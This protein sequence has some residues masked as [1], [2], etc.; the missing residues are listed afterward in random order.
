MSYLYADVGFQEK[1]WGK[2]SIADEIKFYLDMKYSEKLRLQDVARKFNVMTRIFHE[3]FNVSPKQYLMDLKLK[4]ACRLLTTTE[5]PVSTISSSL[6][7]DDQMAFSKTFRKEYGMS[8]SAYRR[9]S[10]R[11]I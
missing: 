1:S 2:I 9:N 8:P 7:F 11:S 4:K 6:G 3:K 5:L 10:R